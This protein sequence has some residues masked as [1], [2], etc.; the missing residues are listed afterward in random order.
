MITKR[1]DLIQD[2]KYTWI[3][4]REIDKDDIAIL[5]DEYMVSAE[6][7]AD[8]MDADEQSRRYAVV[9]AS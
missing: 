5:T 6:L 4:V 3:D 1:N 2:Q 7:L 8:I 9:T